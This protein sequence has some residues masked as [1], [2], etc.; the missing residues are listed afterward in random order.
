M[1]R[2]RLQEDGSHRGRAKGGE[3]GETTEG[4]RRRGRAR[5]GGRKRRHA[6]RGGRD[7][8]W[9]FGGRW[10]RQRR[11]G[12][13]RR[14]RARHHRHPPTLLPRSPAAAALDKHPLALGSCAVHGCLVAQTKTIRALLAQ[15]LRYVM[16]THESDDGQDGH[17]TLRTQTTPPRTRHAHTHVTS[18]QQTRTSVIERDRISMAAAVQRRLG[19][20]AAM[21]AT[22]LLA[23]TSRRT[24]FCIFQEAV[25]DFAAR[26]SRHV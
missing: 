15:E 23:A 14:R 2:N 18:A 25:S 9:G 3:D 13:E 7:M 5:R 21:H 6:R 8:K 4:R 1:E 22:A 11:N 19:Q 24:R 17:D 20:V 12:A 10:K 26:C 16:G